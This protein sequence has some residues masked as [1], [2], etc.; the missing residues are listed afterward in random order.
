MGDYDGH[1]VDIVDLIVIIFLI[2]ILTD[3]N[4]CG[5]RGLFGGLFGSKN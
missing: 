5:G 2:C 4:Y 3:V 1:Y